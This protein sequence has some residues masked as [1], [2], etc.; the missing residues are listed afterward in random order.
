MTTQPPA[1]VTSVIIFTNDATELSFSDS[2]KLELSPCGASFVCQRAA[3]RGQHPL[4]GGTRIQQRTEFT[5]SEFKDKQLFADIKAVKWPKSTEKLPGGR[6]PDGSVK[7]TSVD[8]CASL[9]L[10]ENK[11]EF[12]VE[13]LC[14]LSRKEFPKR[15][16]KKHG[17]LN[18][19]SERETDAV[20]RLSTDLQSDVNRTAVSSSLKLSHQDSPYLQTLIHRKNS[21]RKSETPENQ[22]QPSVDEKCTAGAH[23]V[24][25]T[26]QDHLS[27]NPEIEEIIAI[28]HGY[29]WVIQ[30]HT[31]EQYPEFWKHPLH[32]AL[33][34]DPKQHT[35]TL[36]PKN[37]T[38]KSFEGSAVSD[39]NTRTS[40]D[41]IC[42][43]SKVLRDL[44]LNKKIVNSETECIDKTSKTQQESVTDVVASTLPAPLP[45]TCGDSHRHK[46]RKDAGARGVDI[47]EEDV[48]VGQSIKVW[49]SNGIIYRL[50]RSHHP[51]VHI[52]PGDGTLIKSTAGNGGFFKHIIPHDG[53]LEE[54]MLCVRSL[55][56]DC[57]GAKYSMAGVL[58]K[59]SRLLQNMM[60]ADLGL[61]PFQREEK[62]CWKEKSRSCPVTSPNPTVII[63]E[64]KVE[65]LG[66]FVAFS[67]GRVRVVFND[68]TTLDM[69]WDFRSRV[70][71][72]KQDSRQ[73]LP[74]KH[75]AQVPRIRKSIFKSSLQKGVC[76]LLLPNG[77]H[78]LV[79]LENPQ[80]YQRYVMVAVE[81]ATWVA[82]SPEERVNFYKFLESDSSHQDGAVQTELQKIK[83][84][85]YILE[86]SL[87][88]GG[89]Q[90]TQETK[91]IN[92]T[93]GPLTKDTQMMT[94]VA[95][96]SSLQPTEDGSSLADPT[97]DFVRD[98]LR[99]TSHT[100]RNIDSVLGKL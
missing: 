62:C 94:G 44:N 28:K 54:R 17:K 19:K 31:V 81:W 39:M 8:E 3:K 82:S 27:Q 98:A 49:F 77:Q 74:V 86:H 75:A 90:Q 15:T 68:R 9:L 22:S 4:D 36:S 32:L 52:Y 80:E 57:P 7:V 91:A 48:P 24:S 84:F 23:E 60:Q 89:G 50:S 34:F 76:Q 96:W 95:S 65:G 97:P 92:R 20:G 42:L 71:E 85:E 26:S 25:C 38:N 63:E 66:N 51:A 11:E 59:A 16:A 47:V 29:T 41:K 64:S 88:P 78:I 69:E 10:S 5:T 37:E 99:R 1:A 58:R 79:A 40:Q 45:L 72:N 6:Q 53:I 21:L 2:T 55:P 73:N 100:I 35:C 13:F 83:C 93:I 33:N 30:H 61:S 46:W 67:N 43:T 70:E 87:S 12:T 56:P 14:K 18:K